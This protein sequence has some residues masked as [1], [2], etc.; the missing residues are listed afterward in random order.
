[1]EEAF[2]KEILHIRKHN[3]KSKVHVAQGFY[4][5]EKMKTVLKWSPSAAYCSV[6]VMSH[7][8]SVSHALYPFTYW[9]GRTF[10]KEEDSRCC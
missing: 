6:N 2:K 4:T 5:K 7:L 1:M 10:D 8:G 9:F 3:K